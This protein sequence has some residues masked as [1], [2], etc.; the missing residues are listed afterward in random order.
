[1]LLRGIAEERTVYLKLQLKEEWGNG[2]LCESGLRVQGEMWRSYFWGMVYRFLQRYALPLLKHTQV[3]KK[4]MHEDRAKI[5]N[6]AH[7]TVNQVR[8]QTDLLPLTTTG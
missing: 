4:G 5:I 2:L 7:N 6:M 3:M 1:M 8:I